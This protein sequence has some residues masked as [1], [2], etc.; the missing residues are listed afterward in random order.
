MFSQRAVNVLRDFLEPNGELLPL[1]TKRGKYYA[2]QTL[3]VADGVL[4]VAKTRGEILKAP[5]FGDITTYSFYKSKL[6]GLTIFRVR[7]HPSRVLVT[8]AFKERVEANGL[9][10]FGLDQLCRIVDHWIAIGLAP[11]R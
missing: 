8:T 2:Y 3:T 11:R 6:E 1:T 10:G 9:L 5:M 4:N 7:E